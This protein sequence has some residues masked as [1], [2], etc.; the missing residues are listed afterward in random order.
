MLRNIA[1]PRN[2]GRLEGDGWVETAG[3]GTV[4]D[5]LFLFIE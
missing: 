4:D 5:D 1:E 3:D 2:T